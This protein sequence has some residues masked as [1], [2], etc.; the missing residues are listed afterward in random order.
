MAVADGCAE[1]NFWLLWKSK[2]IILSCHLDA[3]CMIRDCCRLPACHPCLH[4]HSP[5]AVIILFIFIGHCWTISIFQILRDCLWLGIFYYYRTANLYWYDLWVA[6][7]SSLIRWIPSSLPIMQPSQSFF[8]KLHH[9][10]TLVILYSSI[11]RLPK[12]AI[13]DMS[14]QRVWLSNL[15]G[16][17][18]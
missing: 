16:M 2:T 17:V 7:N 11:S 5:I 18:S 8:I 4:H 3:S 1:S 15:H 14:S 10:G 13:C 9:V 12:T 6:T